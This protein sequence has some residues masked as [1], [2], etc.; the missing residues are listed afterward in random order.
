MK[1]IV[2]II[3]L[4]VVYIY[5]IFIGYFCNFFTFAILCSK[6]NN[7]YFIAKKKYAN[8]SF[9]FDTNSKPYGLTFGKWTGKW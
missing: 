1:T 5:I 6:Q 4:I 8:Q 9:V 2:P 3:R 7:Y